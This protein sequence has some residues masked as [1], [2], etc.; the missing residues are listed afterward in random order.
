MSRHPEGI[1]EFSAFQLNTREQVLSYKG[2]MIPLQPKLYCL[3]LAMIRS[4]GALL[5]KEELIAEVWPDSFVDESNLT[6]SISVLRKTLGDNGKGHRFIETIPKRGYRFIAGVNRRAEG[7]VERGTEDRQGGSPVGPQF[8]QA[9]AIA[10]LPFKTIASV[11]GDEVLSV[12]IMDAVI[13]RLSGF[14]RLVVRPTSMTRKYAGECADPI[15]AGHQLSTP[16]IVDGFIQVVDQ[17]LR[18][19]VQLINAR[20][21]QVIWARKFDERVGDL[22]AIQDLVS[23]RIARALILELSAVV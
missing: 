11:G 2:R 21:A 17:T 5:T 16:F 3:L 4:D 7:P 12:G 18:I 14:K 13:E 1:Y 8:S 22:L 19:N 20:E 10:V 6:V 15:T 9:A 23:E